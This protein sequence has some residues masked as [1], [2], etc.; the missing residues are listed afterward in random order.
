MLPWLTEPMCC[1]DRKPRRYMAVDDESRSAVGNSIPVIL[2]PVAQCAV[3]TCTYCICRE[4]RV[5]TPQK[6]TNI[7]IF[8]LVIWWI[9]KIVNLMN[10]SSF[11]GGKIM[12]LLFYVFLFCGDYSTL[13]SLVVTDLVRENECS[14]TVHDWGVAIRKLYWKQFGWNILKSTYDLVKYMILNEYRL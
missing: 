8:K 13:Q 5:S 9:F 3:A 14:E 1:W 2:R 11:L 4:Q 12:W 10:G 7:A 6:D